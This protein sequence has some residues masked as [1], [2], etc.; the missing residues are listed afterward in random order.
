MTLEPCVLTIL[1]TLSVATLRAICAAVQAQ[2]AIAGVRVTKLLVNR[3]KVQLQTIKLEAVQAT[4]EAALAPIQEGLTFYP[5]G[6][7]KLVNECAQFGDFLAAPQEIIAALLATANNVIYRVREY[8]AIVDDINTEIDR[9]TDLI[10]L[11]DEV[12]QLVEIIIVELTTP[13]A[14]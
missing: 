6:V 14:P 8:T 11:I 3:T 7:A 2:K 4:Y 10:T 13:A 12:C 9:L 5:T 1:R